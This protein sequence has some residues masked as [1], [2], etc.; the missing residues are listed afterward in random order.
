[1]ARGRLVGELDAGEATQD[2]VMALAVT[3]VED[4]RVH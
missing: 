3:E 1:M 4:A 2:S